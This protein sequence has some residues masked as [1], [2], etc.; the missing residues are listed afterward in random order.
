MTAYIAAMLAILASG[1]A[2]IAALCFVFE[3]P[4]YFPMAVWAVYIAIAYRIGAK[5]E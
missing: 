3:W 5:D 1:F 4:L 2:V